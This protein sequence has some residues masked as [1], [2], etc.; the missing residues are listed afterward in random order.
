M[1]IFEGLLIPTIEV[2]KNTHRLYKYDD[3]VR[4]LAL[5]VTDLFKLKIKSLKCYSYYKT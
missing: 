3:T 2:K 5:S 4:L 1:K